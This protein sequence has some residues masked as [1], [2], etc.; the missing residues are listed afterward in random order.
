[1]SY[2]ATARTRAITVRVEAARL[3]GLMRAR[4]AATQS[5]LINDL[6]EEEAERVRCER[7]LRDTTG[8]AR[9]SDFD[10]R[11]L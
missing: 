9:A 6:L 4:K 3:R 2:K 10:D 1:M 7:V 5:E 11:L 8:V